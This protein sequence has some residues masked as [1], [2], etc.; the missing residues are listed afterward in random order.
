M[1][2]LMVGG[3]TSLFV[4]LFAI[5]G[6]GTDS[7]PP[8]GGKP[9]VVATFSILGDVV[10]NVAGDDVELVTLVGP[11]GDAHNFEPGPTDVAT[12]GRA[13]LIFENGI[14]FEAWLD[15]LHASSQSKA[16]RVVVTRGLKLIE[17]DEK[18][19]HHTKATDK[20]DHHEHGEHDPHVWS[21]VKNTMHMV[22]I[23]RDALVEQDA[24]HAEKYKANA[25]AY[26]DRL[27]E[28][29]GWVETQVATIPAANRKLVTNHDTFGYFAR[30]YGFKIVGNALGSFST[31]GGDPSAG[32]MAKLI[33]AIK[34]ENVPA[35]FAENVQ[36][37]KVVERLANDAGVKLAPPLFTDALGKPGT[38]GDT[39]VKMVRH[40]VTVIV[41][42][43]K[44]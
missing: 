44:P 38:D 10:R 29:D 7:K 39:Y 34:R 12:L 2:N 6:C 28:L 16:R 31:E 25:T 21:D 35:I 23:I 30:R 4:M 9:R 27:K 43:L 22:G 11:D 40:N 26:L 42:N 19:G 24:A 20:H 3:M 1:R 32:Q 37:P 33:E 15:K 13:D 41:S 17:A 8:T 36:N 14:E 5:V 18:D